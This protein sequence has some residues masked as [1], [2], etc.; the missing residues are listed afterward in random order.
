MLLAQVAEVAEAAKTLEYVGSHWGFA[1]W[2]VA[3]L[4]GMIGY[5]LRTWFHVVVK[6]E[7]DARVDHSERLTKC[8]ELVTTDIALI[9][10]HARQKSDALDR[11]DRTIASRPCLMTP[12]TG[13]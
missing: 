11:I 8:V 2:V 10:E 5:G 3:V 1:A 9:K 4:L 7:S 6:P 13:N 12:I